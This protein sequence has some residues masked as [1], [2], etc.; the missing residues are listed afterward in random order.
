MIN[1]KEKYKEQRKFLAIVIIINFLI[2]IYFSMNIKLRN[3]DIWKLR[4]ENEDLDILRIE[5][6]ILENG[7][8]LT[9]L[10]RHTELSPNQTYNLYGS[11]L[12]ELVKENNT[13]LTRG[14][15]RAYIKEA[16][17][18]MNRVKSVNNIVFT[19]EL[20]EIYVTK[21]T[22]ENINIRLRGVI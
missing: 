14:R 6:E 18:K 10:T 3:E 1:Y 21:N 12:Y 2:V 13:Q 16:L 7:I 11:R 17:E 5:D 19:D 22:G 8:I 4:V 15:I 9:I 20:I